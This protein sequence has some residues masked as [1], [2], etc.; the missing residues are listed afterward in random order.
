MVR[1]FDLQA[2]F[3]WCRADQTSGAAQTTRRVVDQMIC[4]STKADCDNP[5]CRRGGCQGRRPQL[6]LF[7]P[8][9][10]K[11]L[12]PSQLIAEFADPQAARELL[13]T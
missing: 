7:Q 5:G 6:P 13:A 9:E 12:Q 10:I 1:T 4:P 11:P 3:F 2:V 8:R